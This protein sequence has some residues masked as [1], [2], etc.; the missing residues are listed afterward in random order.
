MAAPTETRAPLASSLALDH[1]S[2]EAPGEGGGTA[3]AA[4][5]QR[6]VLRPIGDRCDI[7]AVE[8]L[9][10]LAVTAVTPARAG[11]QGAAILAIGGGGFAPGAAVVLRRVGQADVVADPVAIETAGEALTASFDLTNAALGAWDV[12]VTNPDTTTAVLAGGFIVEAV[13]EP[14]LYAAVVGRSAARAGLPARY[15]VRYGNRGNTEALAVPLTLLVP[16][17]F[18]PTMRFEIAPPPEQPGRPFDDYSDVPLA[19]TTDVVGDQASLPFVIPIIPPGF[20]GILEFTLTPPVGIAHGTEFE[21]DAALGRPWIEDGVVR[22]EVVAD[23]AVRARAFANDR[24]GTTATAALDPVLIAYETNAVTLAVASSRATLLNGFG[25]TGRAYSAAFLAIDLAGYAADQ[26]A[27]SQTSVEGVWRPLGIGLGLLTAPVHAETI[28]PRCTCPPPK[29]GTPGCS[30]CPDCTVT[31][32]A[33]KPPPGPL[34]PAECRSLGDHHPSADGTQCIPND[35]KD[36]AKLQN[37]FYTDPACLKIPLKGSIDPNDKTGSG[38]SG[39]QRYVPA[40]TPMPYSIAF[41]NL[42]A[43]TAPAQTVIITDQLDTTTL[44]LATFAL[45]PIMVGDNV[46]ITPLGRVS[47]TFTGGADLRPARDVILESTPGST[48]HRHRDLAFTSLDPTT[49]QLARRSRRRLPAAEHGSRRPAT[50]RC[51][52]RSCRKPASRAGTAI[53][54]KAKIDLRRQC[55]DRHAGMAEHRST[56]CRRR[57]RSTP[58]TRRLRRDRLDGP[59]VG[60]RCRCAHR[61]LLRLRLGRRR[62]VL[63][64]SSSTPPSRRRRSPPRSARPTASTRSRAI[65][66]TTSRRRRPSRTSRAR[67]ARAARTTSRSSGS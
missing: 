65:R 12:V 28:C 67:S 56:R 14:D 9:S 46:T 19:V 23:A 45:G 3:C 20:T 22:P 4:V 39:P 36:C 8:R 42:P 37:V 25:Q 59:L 35:T 15:T 34:T 11:D 5:D 21:I 53:K 26:A 41:E 61:R 47:A 63:R 40:D 1:G 49:L 10:V 7:G 6:G 30:V 50:A 64:R 32:R 16:A 62:P 51:T 52:S 31:T 43:A 55:T 18:A 58:S 60:H 57:A 27:A 13:R 17:T 33:P 44:D 29:V 66:R 48:R 38:G 24:L 54:N 2:P